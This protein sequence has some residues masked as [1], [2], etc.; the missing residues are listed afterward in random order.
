MKWLHVQ[1]VDDLLLALGLGQGG[2]EEGRGR[3]E[4]DGV[5]FERL[6]A[7]HN[8]DVRHRVRATELV[9]HCEE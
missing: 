7:A 5:S 4:N 6:V 8:G 1:V 9:H 3:A 2:P